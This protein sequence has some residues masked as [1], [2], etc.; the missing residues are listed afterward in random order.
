MEDTGLMQETKE[1]NDNSQL[2]VPRLAALGLVAV[3]I[4]VGVAIWARIFLMNRYPQSNT[5]R[6]QLNAT[7]WRNEQ[8]KAAGLL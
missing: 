6:G 3:A 1:A 2:P 8:K 4:V 5:P 7:I